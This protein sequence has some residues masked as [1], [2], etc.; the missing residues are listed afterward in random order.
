MT[1]SN[2]L[3]KSYP[4][5]ILPID[6]A[7]HGTTK[8]AAIEWWYFEAYLNNNYSVVISFTTFSKKHYLTFPSIEIYK[9][10]ELEVRSVKRYLF[11]DFEISNQT[12]LIKI[13][14]KKMIELDLNRFRDRGEW[15][16]NVS[17]KIEDHEVNLEFMGI[18][19]GWR[20]DQEAM[21]WIVAL[22]KAQV[23]GEIVVHGKRMKVNGIGYHD[24][25]WFSN[26]ST[27]I[28]IWGWYWGKIASKTM[29]VVWADIVK[30]TSEE[31]IVAVVNQDNQRYITINPK[32]I[33]F[34]PDKF[35]RNYGRKMPSSFTFQ[36]DDNE[37]DIPIHVD[38]EMVKKST[39]RRYKKSFFV[40][41]WRYQV[42][43]K[44][45][46]SVGSIRETVDKT[47][48][49]EFVRMP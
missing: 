16:Y 35:I 12:P 18:T 9:D 33:R 34:K 20:F 21:I 43:A 30:R 17:Y 29:N 5:D 41:Y 10:G 7:Y 27:L 36:I 45:V 31:V 46:I 22:P 32:N 15:V 23:S 4:R 48:G 11:Q 19:P 44:G 40:P 37:N 49:M 3:F 6:D 38:V 1:R 14:D 24:H 2:S 42:E 25:N 39:H 13:F 47:Q 28:D 26:L 8:Y